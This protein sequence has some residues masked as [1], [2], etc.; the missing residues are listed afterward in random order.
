MF[1]E[2]RRQATD[3][4]CGRLRGLRPGAQRSRAVRSPAVYDFGLG[5]RGYEVRFRRGTNVTRRNPSKP[6]I[7]EGGGCHL[8]ATG[9]GPLHLVVRLQSGVEE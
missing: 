3:R 5:A 6:G 9:L 7:A 2:R 4:L 1:C 8:A